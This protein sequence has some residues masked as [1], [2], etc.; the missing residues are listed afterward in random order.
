MKRETVSRDFCY[1]GNHHVVIA[2]KMHTCE[3]RGDE[4]ELVPTH[5]PHCV[6]VAPPLT[7]P[8]ERGKA[9]V[10]IHHD[11]TTINWCPSTVDALDAILDASSK[12]PKGA[13]P[14]ACRCLIGIG[15]AEN[16]EVAA[17]WR[18]ASLALIMKMSCANCMQ[19]GLKWRQE[20][21]CPSLNVNA[22]RNISVNTT[23]KDRDTHVDFSGLLEIS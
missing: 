19:I 14:V 13:A 5:F 16:D 9:L 21:D 3:D 20:I 8:S 23:L 22:L 7:R 11:T 1:H 12:P 15:I 18:A 2:T 17:Q 4:R 6:S 10:F